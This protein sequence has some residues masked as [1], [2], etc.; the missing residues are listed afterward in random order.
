M[1]TPS[2]IA[3]I[4][5]ANRSDLFYQ[6]AGEIML[7]MAIGATIGAYRWQQR[8]QGR[9]NS[10]INWHLEFLKDLFRR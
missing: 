3:V 10:W 6:T 9:L 5:K 2:L 7:F 8:N 4:S 1:I